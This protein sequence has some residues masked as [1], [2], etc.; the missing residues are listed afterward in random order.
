MPDAVADYE[1]DLRQRGAAQAPWTFGEIWAHNTNADYQRT[2][3]GSQ[4]PTREAL[5]KLMAGVQEAYPGQDISELAKRRGLEY[6]PSLPYLLPQSEQ[7]RRVDATAATLGTLIDDLPE[8]QRRPLEALRDVR[9]NAHAAAQKVERDREEYMST[10]YGLSGNAWGFLASAVG[11]M[12]SPANVYLGVATG[13]IGGPFKGPLAKV[14]TRQT[15]AGGLAELPQ[16]PLIQ[17]RR[18]EL[19]LAAGYDE[20]LKDIGAAAAF[21]GG[22][23]LGV[24]TLGAGFRALRPRE[25][26]VR[27]AP[28]AEPRIEAPPGAAAEAPPAEPTA[29]RPLTLTPQEQQQMPLF[30]AARD[31][32]NLVSREDLAAAEL[33]HQRDVLIYDAPVQTQT[34][35]GR[36]AHEARVAEATTALETGKPARTEPAPPIDAPAYPKSDQPAS[37]GR[38][39]VERP[40]GGGSPLPF[41][42]NFPG[43]RVQWFL[44]HVQSLIRPNGER[45][46]VRPVVMELGDV[47]ASHDLLGRANPGYPVAELQPRD[48]SGAASQLFVTEKAARLEPELL[49]DAPTAATGAPVIGPDGIVESGNGRVLLLQRA[50]EAHPERI[51]AY[52][53]MLRD[54]G[55]D[56]DGFQQP[57]LMRMREG[58]LP[59]TARGALAM[60]AN[61]SPTAGLSTRERAFSDAK[62]LSDDL[63]SNHAGGDV[64]SAANRPFVRA[65]AEQA[66]APEERPNFIDANNQLS[67]EG[68]RRLEA[69]LVARAWGQDDIVH[70][71]YESTDPT[72]KAILGAF[73]DS[74]PTVARMRAAI[75]EGRIPIESDPS[76]HFVAAFRLVEEARAGGPRLPERLAQ[77]DIERGPVPDEVAAAVRLYFRNDGLT[78]AAGR[79]KIAEKIET[80]A[81]RALL[82]M[83]AAGDLFGRPPTA[84]DALRA[85]RL[86]AENVDEL[87]LAGV[88]ATR[89]AVTGEPHQP[90]N[91][92]ERT[93]VNP[94]DPKLSQ[95]EK[96]AALRVL[97][98][99]NAPIVDNYLFDLDLEF[100]TKSKSNIKAPEKILEKANRPGVKARKPW[101]DVEHIRDSFRF[102]TELPDITQLPAIIERL[103]ENFEIIKRDTGKFFNPKEWGFRI[104]PFDLRMPNGQLVEYY[105]PLTEMQA[106]QDA[107]GGHLLFEKW[108]NKDP[109]TLT[110]AEHVEMLADQATSR[111][112][113]DDAFAAYKARTGQTD[114]DVRA[115]LDQVS[116]SL[117]ESRLSSAKSPT[118]NAGARLQVPSVE[119]MATNLSPESQTT[120]TGL[121]GSPRYATKGIE[122]STPDIT[123]AEAPGKATAWPKEGTGAAAKGDEILVYRLAER[124]E[125]A[126]RNA[127]NSEG[128]AKLIERIDGDG[129]RFPGSETSDTIFAYR[130]KLT[131]DTGPYVGV[132]AGKESPAFPAKEADQG[133][134]G[135]EAEAGVVSYFFPKGGA[136]YT[137]ELLGS[138]PL[139]KVREK[140]ELGDADLAGRAK[141]AEAIRAA[142]EESVGSKAPIV[143]TPAAA[144]PAAE[145]AR[146]PAAAPG[147]AAEPV[148]LGDP[149]LRAE[150]E[151]VLAEIPGGVNDVEITLVNPDGSER[152]VM[153][154]QLLAE[155]AQDEAAAAE[156]ASCV[157]MSAEAA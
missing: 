115:A 33:L 99:E 4:Q 3:E 71:L 146:A 104:I 40:E 128:V 118:V 98:D 130:V 7:N 109:N 90:A 15:V 108:R 81:N 117:S 140:L 87:E 13:A 120:T 92:D 1:L 157:G 35:Q 31:A 137:H 154:R 27:P 84:K 68:V 24:R 59:M 129:P 42:P 30:G 12:S 97:T 45:M 77:I 123:T 82:Q 47:V 91:I 148:P 149:V 5:G 67:S 25:P 102:K 126:G 29:P 65:F 19:G 64:T 83:N 136:G 43:N 32:S 23:A 53:Q 36:V 86:T 124:D 100:G 141:T 78:V 125:L 113:Y 61:I 74:A 8:E 6:N 34:I 26:A 39:T 20:A 38:M 134:V 14:L 52:Q 105:L 46:T 133:R 21:G 93:I 70:G 155:S 88:G 138:V 69:A 76:P 49:G 127:G 101:H 44:D 55:Y 131:E 143:P 72:S 89:D 22:L 37:G 41:A 2:I 106:A 119:R 156:L 17:A 135:S 139:A 142:F 112:L 75:E 114:S 145:P 95:P 56:L 73:A 144:K 151:R 150:A 103:Q 80:A 11:V 116:A 63:M 57:V 51:A 10:V 147:K 121:S 94:I 16:Q 79:A 152:K 28:A 85:A 153:A 110:E 50:Y 54:R 60:E 9:G 122:P 48:R 111:K 132:V 96:V 107:G 66:V 18:G 58:D 62:Y